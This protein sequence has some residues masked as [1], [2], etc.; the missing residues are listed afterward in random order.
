MSSYAAYLIKNERTGQYVRGNFARWM[1]QRVD[2]KRYELEM[3]QE[4]L[5]EARAAYQEFENRVS[6]WRRET[7]QFQLNEETEY[8]KR[9]AE[10]EEQAGMMESRVQEKQEAQKRAAESALRSLEAMVNSFETVYQERPVAR[11]KIK[12]FR[13]KLSATEQAQALEAEITAYQE[14]ERNEERR[15]IEQIRNE[16]RKQLMK[17]E[18][19]SVEMVQGKQKQGFIALGGLQKR[20]TGKTPNN[21]WEGFEAQIK[22]LLEL[23]EMKFK[24]EL[25]ELLQ[26]LTAC[27]TEQRDY[28][29]EQHKKDLSEII[30]Q[31]HKMML[32]RQ[33]YLEEYQENLNQYLAICELLHEKPDEIYLN[34]QLDGTM[35]DRLKEEYNRVWKKYVESQQQQYIEQALRKTFEK[36]GIEYMGS[37]EK[38][39]LRETSMSFALDKSGFS[40]IVVTQNGSKGL[41]TQYQANVSSKNPSEDEKKQAAEAAKKTCGLI[42]RVIEEL[43]N[44]YGIEFEMTERE[45]PS[46]EQIRF[47]EK[48]DTAAY[49]EEQQVRYMK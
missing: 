9:D 19:V 34:P 32:D 24:E 46:E 7:R 25:N 33:K 29:A 15:A 16:E 40:E 18:K 35:L 26:D 21:P 37:T 28:Y 27:P 10:Q 43:K 4:S 2:N 11:E 47:V 12:E 1:A 6:D 48:T 41:Q 36:Y 23:P 31:Q 45:E 44:E 20:K 8:W 5:N 30:E 14:K 13:T 38:K 22:S 17:S 39:E 3:C 42:D 49:R